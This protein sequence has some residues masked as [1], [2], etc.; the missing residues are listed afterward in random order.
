VTS[1]QEQMS[2]PT[3][4]F[5]VVLRELHQY[6]E[7]VH[8]IVNSPLVASTDFT[9]S[10]PVYKGNEKIKEELATANTAL[11]KF[12]VYFRNAI[13]D[14]SQRLHFG[15]MFRAQYLRK[16]P[17]SERQDLFLASGDVIKF[18]FE[19]VPPN[20]LENPVHALNAVER[21]PHDPAVLNKLRNG[22]SV[23][24]V[25]LR[26][27]LKVFFDQILN[28]RRKDVPQVEV[29]LAELNTD[30]A[31][32]FEIVTTG[33]MPGYIFYVVHPLVNQLGG[34]LVLLPG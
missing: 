24:R 14:E 15:K 3:V 11:D 28:P 29:A 22:E 1:T 17:G 9:Y 21:T 10:A 6:R 19:L 27:D 30:V 12:D 16:Y 31:F 18:S 8:Q 4:I 7:L 13:A 20:A 25:H 23:D 26:G 5:G 34:R 33:A 32:I 2:G